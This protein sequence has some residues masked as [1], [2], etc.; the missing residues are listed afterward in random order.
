MCTMELLMSRTYALL[1]DR[2][3][4][5]MG[6]SG[7][8]LPAMI[9]F[10][11]IMARYADVPPIFDGGAFHDCLRNA[12]HRPFDV[13]NYLCFDHPSL[14]FMGLFSVPEMLQPGS[15]AALHAMMALLGMAAIAAFAS[16]AVRLAPGWPY[17]LPRMIA[18][19]LFALQPVIVAN[20]VNFNLDAGVVFFYVLL[21]ACLL[22]RRTL[23]AALSG[24]ALLFTKETGLILYTVTL[25][26]YAL[27]VALPRMRAPADRRR[28]FLRGSLLLAPIMLLAWYLL[29]RAEVWGLHPF[30]QE[31]HADPVV[32]LLSRSLWERRFAILLFEAFL[33]QFL[34]VPALSWAAA[35]V[36]LVRKALSGGWRS[37]SGAWSGETAMIVSTAVAVAFILTR[38]MPYNNPRYLMAVY[39]LC[40]LLTLAGVRFLSQGAR[41]AS[42]AMAV[43]LAL[44]MLALFRSSD[45][46]SRAV[47]GTFAFGERSMYPLAAAAGDPCCGYGRDQIVYN[48]EH[49][50]LLELQER[51]MR[52]LLAMPDLRVV[53]HPQMLFWFPDRIDPATGE[54]R[55]GNQGIRPQFTSVDDL[56]RLP[57][58][59]EYVVLVEYPNFDNAGIRT[60][61]LTRYGIVRDMTLGEGGYA[62]PVSLARRLPESDPG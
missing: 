53:I 57:D 4:S 17:R 18:V 62:L 38:I 45:P 34:W 25:A 48:L 39:P 37:V 33:F 42:W 20:A 22:R 60:Q 49:L 41:L 8:A 9:V 59:P 44:N 29:V 7:E 46:V 51:L 11:V 52:G 23:L 10:G 16:L 58:L 54:S 56:L 30:H 61:L 43:F 1:R 13:R 31:P 3:R 36:V 55:M 40:V 5:A 21:L 2:L 26:L 47:L 15:A 14:A 28:S 35:L 12:V 19:L 32:W 24:T 50:K 6:L 27:L